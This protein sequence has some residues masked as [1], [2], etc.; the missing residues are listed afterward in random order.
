MQETNVD[1]NVRNIINANVLCV[2]EG[3]VIGYQQKYDADKWIWR[4]LIV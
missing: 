2:N 4:Y 3:L 1:R